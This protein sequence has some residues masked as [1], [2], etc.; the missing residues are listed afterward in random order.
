VKHCF[1]GRPLPDV[2]TDN[3]PRMNCR[4]CVYGPLPV[5]RAYGRPVTGSPFF[6]DVPDGNRRAGRAELV[7]IR[8]SKHAR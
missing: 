6:C 4:P 7:F 3:Q 5:I 8:R 1:R 2:Q